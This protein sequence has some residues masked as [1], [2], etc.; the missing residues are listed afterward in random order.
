MTD[1]ISGVQPNADGGVLRF[2]CDCASAAP[3][4]ADPWV[5]VA[6]QHKLEDGAKELILDA[7]YRQPRTV[8]QLARQLRLSPPAVHR[9]ITELLA[10][11]LIREAP[12]APPKRRSTLERYYRPAFPVVLAADRRAFL[13]IL[14]SLADAIADRFRRE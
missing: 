2:A 13:P 9:H 12:V 4:A 8:T 11:E 3:V 6:K 14:A 5:A 1:Q 7:I 10:S